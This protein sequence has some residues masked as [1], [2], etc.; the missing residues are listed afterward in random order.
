MVLTPYFATEPVLDKKQHAL[1]Q[2][3]HTSFL[4]K[5]VGAFAPQTVLPSS[6]LRPTIN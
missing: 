5:G 4:D 6:A 2:D 3:S 1:D